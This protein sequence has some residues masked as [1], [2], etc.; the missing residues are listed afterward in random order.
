V[1]VWR[2][3]IPNYRLTD[4]EENREFCKIFH[5]GKTEGRKFENKH[6]FARQMLGCRAASILPSRRWRDLGIVKSSVTRANEVEWPETGAERTSGLLID[7]KGSA[8][9]MRLARLVMLSV[10]IVLTS[11]LALSAEWDWL[12]LSYFREPDLWIEL[13]GSWDG[14]VLARGWPHEGHIQWLHIASGWSHR[15]TMHP[16]EWQWEREYGWM[17]FR[18]GMVADGYGWAHGPLPKMEYW[19][20]PLWAAR[21]ASA[22]LAIVAMVMQCRLVWRLIDARRRRRRAAMGC[23][24][25]CGY[26]LRCSP[27]RCPECGSARIA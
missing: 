15:T 6:K 22:G 12:K 3:T 14:L 18:H 26:D 7:L 17:G 23:C 25:G 2:R 5:G 27:D 8:T 16:T 24:V 19:V 4:Q 10:A 9:L 13:D 11:T 1:F 20:V 21:T